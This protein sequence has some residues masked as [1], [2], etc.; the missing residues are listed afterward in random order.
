MF[1]TN[2]IEETAGVFILAISFLR[3]AFVFLL[4]VPPGHLGST[5]PSAKMILRFG[6]SLMDKRG[7]GEDI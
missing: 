7:R 5:P 1:S 4:G 2:S 3:L 6:V